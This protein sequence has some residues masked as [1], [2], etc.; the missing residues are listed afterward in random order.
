MKLNAYDK[1]HLEQIFDDYYDKVYAFLYVRVKNTTLAEDLASRTFL[2]VAEKYNTYDPLKGALSTWIFTIA[3]NQLRSHYRVYQGKKTISLEDIENLYGDTNVEDYILENEI[4][5]DL[6]GILND[7]DE[8][9]H[10]IVTLK[11]YGELSN[12]EISKLL[13]ISETNVST[14]LNR[15]IKKLKSFMSKC[16][17]FAD[18]AYK[19]QEGRNER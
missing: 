8:R 5:T 7:L 1:N 12:K 15:T 4:K 6:Q 19:G 2:K 9:Q 13:N 3:L 17:E 18:L 10:N 11:Y 14:I 16:D